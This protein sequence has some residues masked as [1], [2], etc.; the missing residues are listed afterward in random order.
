[1]DTLQIIFSVVLVCL[2]VVLSVVGIQLVLVLI[3]ARRTIRRF[4]Q[5]LDTVEAKLSSFAQPLMALGGAVSGLK[6]G[7]RIFELFVQW[8]HRTKDEKRE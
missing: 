4:N 8:L 5:T 3:E 7:M 6:T 1:M 2:A